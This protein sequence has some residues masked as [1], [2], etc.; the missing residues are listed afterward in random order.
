MLKGADESSAYIH[1]A[2]I[3]PFSD[4]LYCTIEA[5]DLE[6]ALKE[7]VKWFFIFIW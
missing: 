2:A 4:Y 5:T 6:K 7:L 1:I 3:A